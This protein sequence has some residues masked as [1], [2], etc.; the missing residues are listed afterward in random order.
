MQGARTV[1]NLLGFYLMLLGRALRKSRQSFPASQRF[2]PF[3]LRDLLCGE[4]F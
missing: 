2:I 3:L 4:L 1:E